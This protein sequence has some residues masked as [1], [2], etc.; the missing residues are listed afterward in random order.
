MSCLSWRLRRIYRRIA[1]KV[2]RVFYI[3]RIREIQNSMMVAGAARSGT[4][5]LA[6]IIVSQL[7][8]RL[9]FEPFH[10]EHVKAFRPF[11]Y[12]QYMRPEEDDLRL[13]AYCEKVFTGAIRDRWIDRQVESILP[14]KRVIKEIRAN[15]FL[16]WIRDRFPSLPL[17]FLIRHPCAV[18]LSRM[19]LNWATDSDIQPF[20]AQ[21]KLVE[22]FLSDK[23]AVIEGARTP[24][25]KHAVIW[26]I[27][28]LV[29][30][31][32]FKSSELNTFFYEHFCIQPEVEVPRV[33]SLI[34]ETY[35]ES[36]FRRMNQPSLTAIHSSA[37]VTGHDK[38]TFWKKA[39]SKDQIKNI[40]TTVES[41]ELD[42][43]YGASPFPLV[44][45][46]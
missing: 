35:R 45:S 13:Q 18:V 20:V 37:V 42:Y 10:C 2:F 21:S 33:F 39:L 36:V 7:P 46:V 3:D 41:F 6:E 43:L 14:T 40:L 22:D 28:N 29:P 15:L 12:F 8:C 27:S 30:I 19:R 9:M 34:E 17:I 25:E 1:G 44:T 24:E 31:K 4:N 26:C 5:W 23:M 38:V 16:R 32:Q 11:H